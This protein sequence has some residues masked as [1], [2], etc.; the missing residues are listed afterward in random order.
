MQKENILS[1]RTNP[2]QFA[3]NNL[4]DYWFSIDSTDSGDLYEESATIRELEQLL[5]IKIDSDKADG[6]GKTTTSTVATST[7]T[8]TNTNPTQ[9]SSEEDTSPRSQ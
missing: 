2:A 4:H 7:T 9:A 5:K 8:T 3:L 1:F 6:S